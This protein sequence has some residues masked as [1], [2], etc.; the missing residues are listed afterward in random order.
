MDFLGKS[1]NDLIKDD[2]K[3]GRG[4]PAKSGGIHQK[5]RNM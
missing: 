4:K 1:L 5:M 2:K 3:M